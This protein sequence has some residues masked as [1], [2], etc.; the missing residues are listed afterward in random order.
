MPCSRC[1][2]V[3]VACI[4]AAQRPVGA[5]DDA[6]GT[7][8]DAVDRGSKQLVE[9]LVESSRRRRGGRRGVLPGLGTAAKTGEAPVSGR[10]HLS[11]EENKAA[12]LRAAARSLA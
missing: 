5:R 6:L 1:D 8:D 2:V 9:R 4:I 12:F 3:A 10:H 7:V 11:A